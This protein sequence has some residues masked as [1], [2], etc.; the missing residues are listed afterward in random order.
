MAA[1]QLQRA[2]AM[3]VAE[4][5][6]DR[7]SLP[8]DVR[9]EAEGLEAL[10]QAADAA[11]HGSK[12]GFFEDAAHRFSCSASHLKNLYSRWRKSDRDFWVLV[13]KTRVRAMESELSPEFVDYWRG[14]CERNQRSCKAAFRIFKRAYFGG[15]AIPGLPGKRSQSQLPKGCTY[16]NLMRYAP[17]SF[18]L[19]AA[20]QGRSAAAPFRPLVFTTRVGLACGQVYVFDDVEH[21]HKVNFLGV[22]RQAMRPLELSCIDL[23]SGCKVAYGLK[24]TVLDDESAKQ[25]IKER[26]MRFLVAHVLHNI[27]YRPEGT[28]LMVERGTAAI[29]PDMEQIILDATD[30]AVRVERSG[31]EGAAAFAGVFEGRSRGNSRF[32]AALESHHNLVHN[33]LA[34]L[35]GQMGKD[36]DHAPEELHGRDRHNNALIQAVAALPPERAA[37]LELPFIPWVQFHQLCDE[38]YDRINHRTEH[39]LEG[40]EAAGFLINEFRLTVDGPWLPMQMI[41]ELPPEKRVLVDSVIGRAGHVH[42]RRMS[43]AEVWERGSGA[44]VKI[45]AQHVAAI[46]G[47]DLAV[48]RLVGDNHLFEFEDRELGPGIHRY[49]A[50]VVSPRGRELLLSPKQTYLVHANPFAVD[51]LFV[52][53]ETPAGIQFLG[54]APRWETVEKLD[55]DA[56]HR[57]MGAAAKIEKELLRP[58]ARRGADLTRQRIAAAQHNSAVLRGAPITPGEKAR[59]AEIAEMRTTAHDFAAITSRDAEE[60]PTQFSDEEIA[61]LFSTKKDEEDE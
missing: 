49:L 53:Q 14:L 35:P 10:F 20:R 60:T 12:G 27:G 19:R 2:R 37:L 34:A 42:C 57:Q 3:A 44:L 61:T 26:D 31:R 52:S 59:A 7:Y 1:H 15:E 36:R 9:I 56:L 25:K 43:P 8:Q 33:E 11:L 21:D 17:S 45:G 46:L 55:V 38:I 47:R 22:N 41:S 30:G 58:V 18:E 28:V 4:S 24:P 51:Q 5:R 50:Q 48:A 54:V 13:N 6:I 29:R 40:W 16:P 23:L 32:K 39:K